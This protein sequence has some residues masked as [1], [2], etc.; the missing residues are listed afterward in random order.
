M[1]KEA[2]D[3][4]YEKKKDH[5]EEIYRVINILNMYDDPLDKEVILILESLEVQHVLSSGYIQSLLADIHPLK[6]YEWI[7]SKNPMITFASFSDRRKYGFTTW[8]HSIYEPINR[9]YKVYHEYGSIQK[10]C[11]SK[12]P[13]HPQVALYNVLYGDCSDSKKIY[14]H[15]GLA[16][17]IM[18]LSRSKDKAG[19][20]IWNLI[21]D[22]KLMMPI[23]GKINHASKTLG[24]TKSLVGVHVSEIHKSLLKCDKDD[25][26]KYMIV[27]ELG[28]SDKALRRMGYVRVS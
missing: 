12:L 3:F 22:N 6:P 2:L 19:F 24:L 10:Y 26:L 17:S 16:R 8:L 15:K 28:D 9:L 25:P 11:R 27:L 20:G 14:E 21:P 7:M 5:P 4:L 23:N 18:M 13:I 1:D